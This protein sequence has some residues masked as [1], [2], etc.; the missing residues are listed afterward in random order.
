M[1]IGV[2]ADTHGTLPARALELLQGVDEIVHAGDV[3]SR[4][5]IHRLETVAPVTAVTGNVDWGGPLDLIY[6]EELSFQVEGCRIYVKHIGGKPAEWQPHL[7]QPRPDVAICGHSHIPL[8]E[9][10]GGVLYVNPGSAGRPR[11]GRGLSLAILTL[12]GGRPEARL[13][14]LG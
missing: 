11:F 5:I 10:Y 1:R 7:P 13:L 3:G 8:I 6:P 14:P 12:E 4:E 9:F 2:I